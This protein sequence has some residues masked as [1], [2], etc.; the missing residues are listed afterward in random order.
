MECPI[1]FLS[2][3]QF[4]C[5]SN[6]YKVWLCL[7]CDSDF[8]WPM[9]SNEIIN[10]F[11]DQEEYFSGK[12][13][14]G[15]EDYDLDTEP[16]IPLFHELINKFPISKN[17]SI[18][19]IGC[20]YGTQL[21][22][23]AEKGLSCWGIEKSAHARKIAN[24]RHGE[25]IK[26]FS[27]VSELPSLEFNLI[28]MFDVIEHLSN[29]YE[30][31]F[32]L[33]DKGCIGKNTTIVITTPNARS[34]EAIIN[35]ATWKYRYPPAH[36]VYYSAKSLKLF[37]S[38]LGCDSLDVNGIYPYE[39]NFILNAK[40]EDGLNAKLSG[41]AGLTCSARNFHILPN[42]K[43]SNFFEIR[44]KLQSIN[45]LN[46]E[47]EIH[48]RNH[49]YFYLK[50][51][52]NE[53]SEAQDTLKLHVKNLLDNENNLKQ[54]VS[55]LLENENNLK[56]HVSN[57]LENENNLKQHV[58]NLLENENNLKQ[59]VS[60]L[61]ENENNQKQHISNL[62]ENE[63]NLKIHISNLLEIQ[64]NL[65]NEIEQLSD[66][67][68]NLHFQMKNLLKNEFRL[69]K[70]VNLLL[71][72]KKMLRSRIN[73]I[74]TSKWFKIRKS[75][76]KEQTKVIKYINI[77]YKIFGFIT[78][79]IKFKLNNKIEKTD[80]KEMLLSTSNTDK[81]SLKPLILHIIPNFFLGGSSRLVTDLV[82]NLGEKY[83][84]KVIT[85]QSLEDSPYP[86]VDV[87]ILSNPS[88]DEATYILTQYNPELIH[89]HYW[90]SC[91]YWWYDIFFQAIKKLDYPAI[92]NI[93]TPIEPYCA[94]FIKRY[95]Y[96]SNYVQEQFGSQGSDHITIYPGS[97]F[98]L[99]IRKEEFIAPKNCIG[100]VYRLE[101]DKLNEQ[102][103]DPF[104]KVAQ[105]KRETKVIIV[106]GGTYLDL[107]IN[108]VKEAQVEEN[109]EFTG[110]V[111]YTSLPELYS[112]MDLFVAPV[113]KE[114]F[115]QVSPFAMNM[116]IP[117]VGYN[118]GGI[119]EILNNH[120]VLA[121]PGDSEKLSEII[122][123][124]LNDPQECAA[125]GKENQKRA[126]E[127]FSL[128]SM[129]GAYREVYSELIG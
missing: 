48:T 85:S 6:S 89:I 51:E 33:F 120:S 113:W 128:E 62:L 63:N 30:L 29:P 93:N 38:S 96:V 81:L 68:K 66:N 59:H 52:I 102:S 28:T 43:N 4:L 32:N 122:I 42:I 54:H 123:N 109:F 64:N 24:D 126:Q 16:V 20:A 84:H 40:S 49:I 107:Y 73:S 31:F 56:Q 86:G 1:C 100:M 37:F 34:T 5:N 67:N 112:R 61:L 35:P 11:Y 12:V 95:I 103:I 74:R 22:I 7:S 110:Y 9:P 71:E 15:Y 14:G 58:S 55:N 97:N 47:E 44:S 129:I 118:V 19:D 121:P 17:T 46:K 80:H 124:L 72:N 26:I 25:K 18:L 82:E 92:E 77:G 36:L 50:H 75:I 57:L 27:D 2:N 21:S 8:V 127:L 101:T 65:K 114:S 39:E 90:G 116:G 83:Q 91:D 23:A 115:G 60:N 53:L 45:L 3:T 119:A 88:S 78:N 108:K 98:D 76:K 13:I 79:K 117:V 125:I 106:G 105:R 41:F 104:I 70:Q 87:T 10:S 94:N 69:K 99:F 111:D